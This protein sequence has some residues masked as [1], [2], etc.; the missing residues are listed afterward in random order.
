MFYF[1]CNRGLICDFGAVWKC[2]DFPTFA[3]A[4]SIMYA[5]LFNST[6]QVVV[7]ATYVSYGS[8]SVATTYLQQQ[9]SMRIG[10][11]DRPRRQQQQQ[12]PAPPRPSGFSLA[13]LSQFKTTDSGGMPMVSGSQ[14]KGLHG[15]GG[16]VR[17]RSFFTGLL[18]SSA[19]PSRIWSAGTI[20]ENTHMRVV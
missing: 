16:Q 6:W 14:R 8:S 13:L 15:H 12:Q 3:H 2:L 19:K 4:A 1:T 20:E 11:F 10:S 5:E 7:L 17:P 9:H 18:C